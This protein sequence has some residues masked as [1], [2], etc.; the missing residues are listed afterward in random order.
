MDFNED[1]SLQRKK[2]CVIMIA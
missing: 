1:Q 2:L